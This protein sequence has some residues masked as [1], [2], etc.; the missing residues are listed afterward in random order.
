MPLEELADDLSR[1]YRQM[2]SRFLKLLA[3][4]VTA[5]RL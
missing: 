2:A 5:A 4:N 1:P 3:G